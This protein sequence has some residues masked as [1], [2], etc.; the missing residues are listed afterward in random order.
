MV[1]L[2]FSHLLPALAIFLYSA[3]SYCQE[4]GG[5]RFSTKWR[6]MNSDTARIIYPYGNDSAA[7]RAANIA[8]YLAKN[9]PLGL[10]ENLR[11]IN[12]VLQPNTVISNGYVG[13]GPFRSEYYLT[14]PADNFEQGSLPWIDQL[15]LHEYRHV[16]QYNYFNR[17]LSKAMGTLFGEEGL[18]LAMNAAVPNWFF[19]G[20]AVF[21]ETRL[22]NQGRGRLPVFL[23]AFPALWQ[24]GKSYSWMKLRN[25][26][27]KDYVP[28][29]YDLGYLM[30]NYGMEKYGADFWPTVVKDASAYKGLFYPFQKAIKKYTGL[31]YS[32]FTKNAFDYYKDIYNKQTMAVAK[33]NDR[34]LMRENTVTN[35]TT[36]YVIGADSLLYLKSSYQQRPGFYL[37]DKYGEQ[38]IR[39]KDIAIDKQMG[40]NN[41]KIV[42]SAYEEH[43]RWSWNDYSIIKIVDIKSGRQKTLATKTTYFSPDISFDGKT[44]VAAK[45]NTTDG[46]SLVFLDAASGK[47]KQEIKDADISFYTTPKFLNNHTVITAARHRNASLSILKID[48]VTQQKTELLNSVPH[49]IGGLFVNDEFVY[50][51]ASTGVKD[52]L[53]KLN[54]ATGN[55]FKLA[56][57][58]LTNYSIN[59]AFG[60]TIWTTFTANG[61]MLKQNASKFNDWTRISQEEFRKGDDGIVSN[62]PAGATN[63]LSNLPNN[64][65]PVSDYSKFTRPVNLHSWRPNYED[66]V[67]SFTV[68][69]NNVLNTFK[70]NLYYLFNEND[71]THTT[72]AAV[73]Y[74]GLFPVLTIGSQYAINRNYVYK[75]KIKEWNEW[76]NYFG[77]NIPLNRIKG[78]NSRFFN[79][80]ST[81]HIRRDYNKGYYRDSFTNSSFSYLSHSLGYGMQVQRAYQQ[82]Y[83]SWGFN[84]NVALRQTITKYNSLQFNA[85]AN[86]YIPGLLKTHSLVL[87]TAHQQQGAPD[88][89][90]ANVFPYARGYA[91]ISANKKYGIALNYHFP[92]MYPDWGFANIF[93]LQRIRGNL[94]YDQNWLIMKKNIANRQL[95]S[96]GAE[97][98][99]DT[100]WWNQHPITVGCRLGYAIQSKLYF[101]EFILPV[102]LIPK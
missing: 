7:K 68:Y 95:Q 57:P 12:I 52:E 14:P 24:A 70:T 73:S 53:Y 4:F 46:N 34:F 59:D 44:I 78:R 90:F 58:Y 71:K 35:Y 60:K 20:D 42:Y 74:A 91:A 84:F 63:I 33:P 8:H 40:Y 30:V 65:F 69:G 36:P 16:Q 56:T 87:K 9:A 88:R 11:K 47:I 23:K 21:Q 28:N 62:T 99:A 13:L 2:K 10:N 43:P 27:F 75:S 67:Y 39:I 15:A 77:F 94:F 98:Y 101:F 85:A 48:A 89:I 5:N 3:T 50:F 83:P 97:I 96:V 31:R 100:K 92:I 45:T 102:T 1:N 18:A 41:G 64:S 72:G 76:D 37:K 38:L 55:L 86:F 6:Q 80:G 32:T 51:T 54:L 61:F 79:A 26:S 19:E 29:H 81:I 82:I 17:G 22:S 49:L 25:G 66:P 93:Y